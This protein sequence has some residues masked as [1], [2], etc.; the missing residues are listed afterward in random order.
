MNES[1]SLAA[2]A[3]PAD[4]CLLPLPAGELLVSRSHAVFC[5]VPAAAL[6]D[7]RAVLAG[8]RQVASLPAD[9]GE[10]LDRHGFFGPP[11][12][13]EDDRATVQ[14]QLTNA[15]NL[16]CSYCCTHSG[17]A[18][19]AELTEAEALG[20]V[21][22]ARALLGPAGRVALLGGE[23]LLVPWA[24]T[25]AERAL[26]HGLDLTLFTNGMPLTDA[27]LA[28][29]VAD[30]TVRGAEVR[31]SLAG[32]TAETCDALSG[33][34]RFERVMAG[35]AALH[36]AG[37]R[38]K[39]DLMLVPQHIAEVAEHL[40]GLRRR[41]PPGTTVA[42]GVLYR[43]GREEGEHLFTHAAELEDALDRIAFAAGEWIAAPERQPLAY[44]RE[45][46]TCAI[47]DHLN[48]RSDGALFTCFKMEEPVGHLRREGFEATLAD[49]RA[50]PHPAASLRRCV[51]CPLATLCGGGCRSENYLYTGDPDD[52]VCGP[53]RVRVIS[54]LLAEDRVTALDWPVHYLV[55]EAEVRGIAVDE[56]PV[57]R[58]S[59]TNL[60]E[61]G[62]RPSMP[63]TPTGSDPAGA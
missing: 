5:P 49:V 45:G 41:L 38:A 52:P 42:L 59:S 21:D 30:L 24:V 44:R 6:P 54:E 46:C 35:L 48:V 57:L 29:R 36:A 22:R 26:D 60:L 7:V 16:A 17:Q 18:R 56:R 8:T 50:H 2:R 28:A 58:R 47:G 62:I 31:V 55:R 25:V 14:L 19:A 11:R 32:P 13:P 34:P 39:I 10:A 20:V 51:A 12:P 4:T 23:P 9:L 3:L 43:S 37:G 1:D 40:P 33:E 27:T 53:W 15:C 63:P 61:G